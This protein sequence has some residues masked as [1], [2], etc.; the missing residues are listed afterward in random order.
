MKAPGAK[1]ILAVWERSRGKPLIEKAMD[2]LCASGYTGD[3]EDP[4]GLPI[5]ERDARLFRLRE[6]MFGPHLYNVADCPVCHER[7][8]WAMNTRE[9]LPPSP[10][11]KSSAIHALVVDDFH[12]RFRLPNSYDL[13]RAS[14]DASYRSDA[15]KLFS[16]FIIEADKNHEHHDP[17]KLPDYLYLQLDQRMAEEDPQADIRVLLNCAACKHEWEMRFD[18]ITYL[19]I[20][21]DNWAKHVLHEVALLASAFGWSESD[22]LEMTPRRRQLYIEMIKR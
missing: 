20:E 14:T 6:Y 17:G 3:K 9:L 1:E 18:I 16:D 7:V 22:I 8:E 10:E 12:I 21:I 19:W 11:K 4:A 5:G 15:R 2:L 13:I